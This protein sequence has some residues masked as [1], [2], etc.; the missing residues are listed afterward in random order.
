M[1]VIAASNTVQYSSD[2]AAYSSA[3]FPTQIKSLSMTDNYTGSWRI[4]FELSN[5]EDTGSLVYGRIY[6]NDVAY[7]T[8]RSQYTYG[9]NGYSEDFT[10]ISISS[11][12]TIELYVWTEGDQLGVQ[13]FRVEFD[14]A[15]LTAAQKAAFFQLF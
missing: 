3:N 4:Y 7:G 12:D 11:G 9:Y 8:T 14:L 5:E 10:S 15:G 13:N 2:A 1:T 6:K